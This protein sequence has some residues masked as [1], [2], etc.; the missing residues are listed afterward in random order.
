[1]WTVLST[2]SATSTQYAVQ[3][4]LL[5]QGLPPL[6]VLFTAEVQEQLFLVGI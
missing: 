1:M 6:V 2:S 5:E 3:L 4:A